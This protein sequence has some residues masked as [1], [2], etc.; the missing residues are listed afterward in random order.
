MPD[1]LSHMYC[2]MIQLQCASV[3]DLVPC[4]RMKQ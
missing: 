1:E 2:I 3:V 4:Y